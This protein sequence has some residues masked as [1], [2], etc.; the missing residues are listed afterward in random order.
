MAIQKPNSVASIDTTVVDADFHLTEQ[1]TDLLEHLE[2]PWNKFLTG[3]NPFSEDS[4][5]YDP[6]PDPGIMATHIVTGRAKIFN[7]EAVRTR[8][9]I[10]EGMELLDV[11]RVLITPGAVMLRLGV[12]HHDEIAVALARA[13]NQFM[14]EE[15]VD[16]SQNLT[17][18][19]TIAGQDPIA[20]AEEIDDLGDESGIVGVYLPTAGVNPPLGDRKYDPIYEACERAD[21]PLVMHGVGAGTMTSFP[22]QYDGFSRAIENHVIAHP[23]Q[24][25]VNL[26]SMVTHGVPERFDVD[27]VCQEAG[28][29]WIPFLM[30]RFDHEYY[31][32]RQDAPLLQ[33]K[34]SEYLRENFYYTSQPIEGTE[35]DPE[36]VCQMARLMGAEENLMF[37]SDYPHHD[38]D[39]SDSI[40]RVFAREFD[41]EE[42]E[43][44]F[45][46]TASE[47]FFS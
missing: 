29:G 30:R 10:I 6:F 17:G 7:P 32:Q 22:V 40:L 45:G 31:Q 23:F 15:I 18:T 24:H 38:F 4:E 8:E 42:I 26:V 25:I 16:E 43:N 2:S 34:P 9:D 13:C 44:I 21:L 19:I 36:Y 35:E 14:L 3:G 20:A 12:V 33:K 28:I 39:H 11:D 47:V 27:F 5:F 46:N 41:T 1:T 37:A